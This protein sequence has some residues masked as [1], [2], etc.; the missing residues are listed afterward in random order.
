MGCQDFTNWLWLE[1]ASYIDICMYVPY[2]W[3]CVCI[4]GGSFHSAA[5][6]AARTHKSYRLLLSVAGDI[7]NN[8]ISIS[9]PRTVDSQV[10]HVVISV[11]VV[12]V[13][14]SLINNYLVEGSLVCLLMLLLLLLRFIYT[15]IIWLLWVLLLFWCGGKCQ[16]KISDIITAILIINQA[17]IAL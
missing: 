16:I 8:Q 17:Q 7:A 1:L 2:V 12:V 9:S 11:V 10:F 4:N 13:V 3:V 14:V 15:P 6:Y 5:S